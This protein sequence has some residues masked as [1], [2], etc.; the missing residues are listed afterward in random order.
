MSI[1]KIRDI[2]NETLDPFI[3]AYVYG[4]DIYFK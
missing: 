3:I 4:S 1:E 2:N